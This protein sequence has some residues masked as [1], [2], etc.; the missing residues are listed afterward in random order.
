VSRPGVGVGVKWSSP[1]VTP[2]NPPPGALLDVVVRAPNGG[3][4]AGVDVL[5][6]SAA[7]AAA[8][9]KSGRGV[10]EVSWSKGSQQMS[11]F[12]TTS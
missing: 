3:V 8:A 2:P 11:R 6:V 5:L 4:V 1:A 9:V 7:A 12:D 10:E